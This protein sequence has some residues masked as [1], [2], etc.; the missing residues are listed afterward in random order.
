MIVTRYRSGIMGMYTSIGHCSCLPKNVA[1][2]CRNA[3][4]SRNIITASFDCH[5]FT[6]RGGN[7]GGWVRISEIC[8]A[9]GISKWRGKGCI[10]YSYGCRIFIFACVN[11]GRIDLTS[12]HHASILRHMCASVIVNESQMPNIDT[13]FP[14]GF[15][16]SPRTLAQKKTFLGFL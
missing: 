7:T 14:R 15:F 6:K 13:S 8:D 2:R 5:M 4:R 9:R 3:I 10:E 11:W 12:Y 16:I 1:C